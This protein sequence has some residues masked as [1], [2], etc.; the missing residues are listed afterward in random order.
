MHASTTVK[1]W[2]H[3]FHD[4]SAKAVHY[5]GHLLHEK[6]FWA[7]LAI[8]ALIAGIF[9]MIVLLGSDAPLQNYRIPLPYGPYY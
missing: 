8:L 2:V 5:A 6:S 4:N 3:H 7:I 9:T 1:H